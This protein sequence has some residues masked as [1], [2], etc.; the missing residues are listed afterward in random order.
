MNVTTL[1]GV[2]LNT[3]NRR[4]PSGEEEVLEIP[5]ADEGRTIQLVISNDEGGALELVGG[6]ELLISE[7]CGTE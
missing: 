3:Y 5:L 1:A 7:R 6:L 4:M 2:H